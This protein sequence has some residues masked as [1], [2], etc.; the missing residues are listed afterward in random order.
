LTIERLRIKGFKSF[1]STCDFDFSGKKQPAAGGFT[2]IVGPNGSGKSNI[3]DALRYVLG[4]S[5]SLR[6]RISRLSDLLFQGSASLSPSKEAEVILAFYSEN[7]DRTRRVTMKRRY[8]AEAG[9]VYYIDGNRAK[10]Q[11]IEVIKQRL[12]L[13]GCQFAFISQG[14]VAEVI[15]QRPMQRRNHLEV[16]FGI[17]RYRKR[18]EDTESKLKLSESEMLRI[19]TLISELN[20]RRVELAPEVTIAVEAKSIIDNLENLRRDYYFSK[21]KSLETK[22]SDLKVQ[23]VIHTEQEEILNKW[24][25]VWSGLSLETESQ[26]ETITQHEQSLNSEEKKL[27]ESKNNILRSCYSSA[28][29]IRSIKNRNSSICNELKRTEELMGKTD[30]DLSNTISERNRLESSLSGRRYELDLLLQKMEAGREEIQRARLERQNIRDEIARI[31]LLC[32]QLE[33]KKKALEE[34]NYEAEREPLVK[35]KGLL[36]NDLRD[37][38]DSIAKLEELEKNTSKSFTDAFANTR[39]HAAAFNNLK[40]QI[41]EIEA[42]IEHLKEVS[43]S[44][45]PPPERML[46]SASR[47][48]K[49]SAKI[50]IVTEVFSCDPK[51]ANAIEIFLGRRRF[52]LLVH[53]MQEAQEGISHLKTRGGGRATFLPL[54]RARPR[55]TDIQFERN[56][57]KN[58]KGIVGWAPE[59]INVKHPWEPVLRHLLG[60]LLI[61]EE[62]GLGAEYVKKGAAFPIAT[63]DGDIFSPTGTISGGSIRQSQ[64]SIAQLGNIQKLEE[65]LVIQSKNSHEVKDNLTKYE[66]LEREL[67]EDKTRI[68]SELSS[69]REHLLNAERKLLN[70][71]SSLTRL[72]SEYYSSMENLKVIRID[73]SALNEELVILRERLAG[74][75]EIPDDKGESPALFNMQAEVSLSEEKLRSSNELI[76]RIEQEKQAL[77]SRAQQMK[78]E[79]NELEKQRKEE[80][81]RIS[82]LGKEYYGVWQ[83]LKSVQDKI[84]KS[85]DDNKRLILRTRKTK[86]RSD[87]A[88]IR[89]RTNS[90]KIA[91]IEEKFRSVSSEMTQLIELWE[92]KFP[93]DR[94]IANRI[95]MDRDLVQTMRKLERELKALGVYNLG[96]LSEDESLLE[97]T[98]FLTEQLE[99]ARIACDEL[100]LLIEETDKQVESLFTT[101]LKNIDM[102]FNELFYRLFGGGEARLQNQEGDNIWERGVE[103]YARPP[104]KQLHNINQL[105]GGE[106]SLTA[107]A[108]L[109]ASLE[110][111][112]VP[113][114]VLDEVDAS[115]DEYNL[116]RF[117]SLAKEYS[118]TIQLIV[119]THRRT[120]MEQA[121]IIYGVTMVE[122]G[123]SRIVGINIDDYRI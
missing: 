63:V 88:E 106:Q 59:L 3:L 73:L 79:L 71:N 34:M 40:R 74:F 33:S 65:E 57:F 48:N 123:L 72:D 105:S 27:T 64:G 36:E 1:G 52:Y 119:M 17:D 91:S 116:I 80:L 90:D 16:L 96:A 87:T 2:A 9:S 111:A 120:T 104:G 39:K 7:I 18:R 97:R 68:S 58:K 56:H 62:Y 35:E 43:E 28:S 15:H 19:Q 114:A 5:S 49:I 38:S 44:E 37:V 92:E 20:A 21:R 69:A 29:N 118:K 23:I 13:S 83:N 6:L 78:S 121:D 94:A 117:A 53:T 47:L 89:L 115:L 11:D 24:Y 22:I 100:T 14:D 82:V 30:N 4:E 10:L 108:H 81:L 86:T 84:N 25:S 31:E 93:Y 67:Q 45:Y 112:G 101:A 42:Q 99:D 50:E 8:D 32:S 109:F 85:S 77:E 61:V 55:S 46:L 70:V 54:E 103:I 26:H 66:T 122:P 107:I 60:D 41:S 95:E 76:N 110:V 51:A 113:L 98:D 75:K 12:N 102:R